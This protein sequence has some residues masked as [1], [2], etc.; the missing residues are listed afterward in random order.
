M[1]KSTASALLGFLIIFS[2]VTGWT[3]SESSPSLVKVNLIVV[4]R[5]N[6]SINDV[7]KEDLTLLDN[8]TQQ[9]IS[10][11][12]QEQHPTKY[13]L[14]IDTSGSLRVLFPVVKAG[15]TAIVQA[16]RT[17][18]TT[19]I[20]RFISSDKIQTV[21]EL[22]SDKNALTNAI[23]GLTVQSGQTALIDGL[24]LAAEYAVKHR[25]GAERLTL[26]LLSDG[27]DRASYYK[28]AQLFKLLRENGIQAF[29][30]GLIG[31]LDSERGLVRRSPRQKATDFLTRLA[32]ETG[33]RAFLLDNP[34]NLPEAVAE[35]VHDIRIHYV[36]GYHPTQNSN[37]TERKIE[38]KLIDTK[39]LGK[40][41][42]ITQPVITARPVSTTSEGKQP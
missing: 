15:V 2:A 38:V 20:I 28:E 35:I 9:T 30:L 6:H 40:R 5:N 10:Y 21:Q 41:T 16:N 7:Q 13:G 12:S 25:V 14:V 36:I 1:N 19:F 34:K 33:G 42:A 18:D 29:A 37:Q 17:E 22:T 3:Q 24:Y 23:N 27:E 31:D 8:G 32:K 11:F 4:D 26:I 39:G